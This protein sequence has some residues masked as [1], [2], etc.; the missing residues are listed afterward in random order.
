MILSS[1]FKVLSILRLD[2]CLPVSCYPHIIK[3]FKIGWLHVMKIHSTYQEI[4]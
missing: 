4:L 3:I 2:S 1:V